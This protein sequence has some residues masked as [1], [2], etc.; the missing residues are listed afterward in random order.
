MKIFLYIT[1]LVWV[2]SCAKQEAIDSEATPCYLNDPLKELVWMP[3]IVQYF[4]SSFKNVTTVTLYRYKNQQ[5]FAFENAF[6][7]GPVGYIYNCSGESLPK[8]GISYNEFYNS[9]KE[10]K[11]IFEINKN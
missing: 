1:L 8:L 10:V 9:A 2:T 4:K 5:F 11:V 6:V 3:D 7:S